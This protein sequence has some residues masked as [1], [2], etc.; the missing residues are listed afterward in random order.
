M[1]LLPLS[2]SYSVSIMKLL[3]QNVCF[4]NCREN[5]VN[6]IPPGPRKLQYKPAAKVS[7]RRVQFVSPTEEFTL[8]ECF[9]SILLCTI[10]IF[11]HF[12]LHEYIFGISPHHPPSHP[13]ILPLISAH[14]A[15]GEDNLCLAGL[16]RRDFS[17]GNRKHISNAFSLV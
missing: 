10:F 13:M 9:S 12:P 15:K 14:Q 1:V 8:Q 7:F 2:H 17:L 6:G 16:K 3:R 4:S 5:Q 11:S